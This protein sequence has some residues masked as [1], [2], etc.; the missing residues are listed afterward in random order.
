VIKIAIPNIKRPS[1]RYQPRFSSSS[2]LNTARTSAL[3]GQAEIVVTFI[4]KVFIRL[5]IGGWLDSI[6]VSNTYGLKGW[7]IS[8]RVGDKEGLSGSNFTSI[9]VG[10]AL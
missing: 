1:F 3:F 8:A 10:S 2:P 9:T 4:L 7:L 6:I 5:G